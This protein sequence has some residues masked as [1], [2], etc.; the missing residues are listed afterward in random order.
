MQRNQTLHRYLHLNIFLRFQQ[1]SLQQLLNFVLDMIPLNQLY[2]SKKQYQ[3]YLRQVLLVNRFQNLYVSN[4]LR[5]LISILLFSIPHLLFMP[6]RESPIKLPIFYLQPQHHQLLVELNLPFKETIKCLFTFRLLFKEL[7]LQRRRPF[8]QVPIQQEILTQKDLI[9]L[10]PYFFQQHLLPQRIYRLML[11]HR[12]VHRLLR[13]IFFCH[14]IRRLL[15]IP[16]ILL[17]LQLFIN[18]L[19]YPFYPNILK[20]LLQFLTQFQFFINLLHWLMVMERPFKQEQQQLLKL[21]LQELIMV[22]QQQ[23][24]LEPLISSKSFFLQQEFRPQ[25][26]RRVL[27]CFEFLLPFI[28]CKILLIVCLFFIIN[29]LYMIFNIFY[30]FI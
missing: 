30:L 8:F 23:V 29:D 21:G 17:Q 11:F 25:R 16:F 3:R 24:I 18:H 27:T 28:F 22:R 20:P 9:F 12:L 1:L 4:L 15:L 2:H 7:Q 26:V 19:V 10:F 14:L 5:V 6:L 13:L